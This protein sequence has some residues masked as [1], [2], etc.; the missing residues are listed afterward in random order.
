M[1]GNSIHLS[2]SFAAVL[3]AAQCER[4]RN[5]TVVEND[6]TLAHRERNAEKSSGKGITIRK[7]LLRRHYPTLCGVWVLRQRPS[8]S[9]E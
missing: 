7:S 5:G 3:F 4:G 8:A 9:P 6:G 1:P 2:I